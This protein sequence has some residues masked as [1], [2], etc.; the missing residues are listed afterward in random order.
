MN[1]CPICNKLFLNKAGFSKH[2]LYCPNALEKKKIDVEDGKIICEFGC[3]NQARFI[4]NTGRGCCSSSV[5]SCSE[6]KRKNRDTHKG[7]LP[8]WKNGHP[9]GYS[10]KK[11]WNCGKTFE[12]LYGIDRAIKMR[13]DISRLNLGR[14]YTQ[15]Q[16]EWMSRN[17]KRKGLG[18]YRKGGGR[19]KHGWYKGIWCDSSWELA[20]V[21]FHLDHGIQFERN[22]DR[23]EYQW[24]G[25]TFR[26][27]PDFK[28]AD[29]TLIEVK[30]WLDDKGR[31]KLAACPGIVVLMK[32]EMAPFLKYALEKYGKDFV[33]LYEKEEFPNGKGH[34][35]KSCGAK[36]LAG[37]IPVSSAN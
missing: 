21:M 16:K 26:Y 28:M 33:K 15:E 34:D 4:F 1:Q 24:E 10:G 5:N 25:K 35:W 36:A 31:A 37:S 22:R 2:R 29:G 6:M 32:N 27:L 12:S 11:A 23:F 30:A 19:G 8:L 3:G 17:A 18:G 9:R 13:H 20:W 14:F 7:K